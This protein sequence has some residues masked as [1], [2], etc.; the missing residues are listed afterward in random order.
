[1]CGVAMLIPDTQD[2]DIQ[3]DENIM[4]VQQF[5]AEIMKDLRSVRKRD[6]PHI[7]FMRMSISRVDVSRDM[8]NIHL[9]ALDA[10]MNSSVFEIDVTH[11]LD[12]YAL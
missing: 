10:V 2:A 5:L 8:V 4:K 9:V 7:S 6:V 3:T 1:M 12:E 11:A